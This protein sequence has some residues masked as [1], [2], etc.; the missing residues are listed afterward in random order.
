MKD[1]FPIGLYAWIRLLF[2]FV[3]TTNVL[4]VP[5]LQEFSKKLK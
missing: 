3:V 2:C 4:T 5:N 1:S